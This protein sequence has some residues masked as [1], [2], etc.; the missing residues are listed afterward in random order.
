MP[1]QVDDDDAFLSTIEDHEDDKSI[2]D[3]DDDKSIDDDDDDLLGS[4]AKSTI[5]STQLESP[6]TRVINKRECDALDDDEVFDVPVAK[7]QKTSKHAGRPK[8]ADYEVA[9]KEVILSAANTYRAFLASQGGFPTSSEEL[10]LVKRS[11]KRAHDDSEM[12]QMMALTPDIVRIVS[13]SIR[14]SFKFLA[15]TVNI[16]VKARGS[17]VRGEAKTKTAPLVEALYGFDS[18]RSKRAIA[19]N[20]KKAEEL[21]SDK[22]FVFA[23]CVFV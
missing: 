19:E 9:A 6:P 3:D 4:P 14:V 2:D 22:G 11:W 18:G 7:A 5:S 23:V 16:K 15:L 20:R 13:F 10:E 1:I 12:D 21:K 17:Q 8:A